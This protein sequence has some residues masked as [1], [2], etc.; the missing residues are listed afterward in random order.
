[1]NI[2][3][4]RIDLGL[5]VLSV[6]NDGQP[7]SL[8]DISDVCEVSPNAIHELEKRAKRNFFMTFSERYGRLEVLEELRAFQTLYRQR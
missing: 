7:L 1:M 8:L 4:E 3:Q 6:V 5:A 2:R